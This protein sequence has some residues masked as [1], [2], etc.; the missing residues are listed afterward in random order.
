MIFKERPPKFKSSFRAVG[1]LIIHGGKFLL[2]HRVRDK[3][4]GAPG[5]GVNP[6]EDDLTAIKREIN[7]ETGMIFHKK[8][9]RLSTTVFVRN[10]LTGDFEYVIFS[11]ELPKLIPIVLSRTEHDTYYWFTPEQALKLP[12]LIADMDACVK[13]FFRTKLNPSGVPSSR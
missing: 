10:K 9:L 4:W 5:G 8:D 6:G 13:L 7:E 12:T 3:T 11:Y 2:L 1:C